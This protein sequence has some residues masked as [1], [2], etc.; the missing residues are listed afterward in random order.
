M[1]FQG[2]VLVSGMCVPPNDVALALRAPGS[3][4]TTRRKPKS[5]RAS[6]SARSLASDCVHSAGFLDQHIVPRLKLQIIGLA[7][8]DL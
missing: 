2:V 5:P 3:G 1:L 8:F 7:K 4:I 6:R